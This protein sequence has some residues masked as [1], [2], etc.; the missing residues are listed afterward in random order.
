MASKDGLETRNLLAKGIVRSNAE[1]T[2]VGIKIRY[3]GAGTVTS[4]DTTATTVVLITSDGGTDTYT[5]GAGTAT[6]GALADAINADGI[7]E[8]KVVDTLRSQATASAFNTATIAASVDADG[9]VVYKLLMD[10][11]G[12]TTQALCFGPMDSFQYVKGHRVHLLQIDYI[13]N[14]TAAAATLK[15]YSRTKTGTEKAYLFRNKY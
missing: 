2:A 7:F 12:A 8:A 5:F 1:D 15:I 13:I 6:M 4:V 9:L 14:N 3:I 11:S 10:T